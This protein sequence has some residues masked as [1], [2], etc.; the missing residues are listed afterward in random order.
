MGLALKPTPTL[1]PRRRS[2]GGR[3]GTRIE[4]SDRYL[5]GPDP[6]RANKPVSEVPANLFHESIRQTD[7]PARGP[8]GCVHRGGPD[9]RGLALTAPTGSSPPPPDRGHMS[10]SECGA[11]KQLAR[12]A[13][14]TVGNVSSGPSMED[15][16]IRSGDAAWVL[17][18]KRP[19]LAMHPSE[20]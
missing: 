5:G 12:L 10:R 7:L 4:I 18:I 17:V 13:S 9:C 14:V 8:M 20:P 3:R 11:Y 15:Q 6:D 16:H 19:R 1:S 2:S